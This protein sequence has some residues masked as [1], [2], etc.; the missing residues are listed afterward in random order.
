MRIISLAAGLAIGLVAC[1]GEK[2]AEQ[3]PTTTPPGEQ[4]AA[5][6]AAAPAGGEAAP[7]AGG[8]THEV[9]ME[10][11]GTTYKYVPNKLTIKSGDV[12]KFT[13][14]SGG[15]H[16]VQFYPDSIPANVPAPIKALAVAPPEKGGNIVSESMKMDNESL[17]VS[18]A[19]APKGTYKFFCAPHH[20]LGMTGEVTVQ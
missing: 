9:K 11:D 7:A 13:S 4:P 16:N 5:P 6:G 14:V 3:Q 19:G 17:D 10:L 12:I 15:P 2:K 20:A 18:F 1:G 8:T